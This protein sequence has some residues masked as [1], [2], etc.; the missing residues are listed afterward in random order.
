M[1]SA[2]MGL[3]TGSARA[4]VKAVVQEA[5]PKAMYYFCTARSFDLSIVSACHIQAFK[6]IES[7]I[8]EIANNFLSFQQKGRGCWIH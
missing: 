7:C 8:T 4:G 1:V 3:Q 2:M 6:N 5:A